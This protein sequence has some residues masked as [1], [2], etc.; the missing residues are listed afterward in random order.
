M[1]RIAVFPNRAKPGCAEVLAKLCRWLRRR[2]CDVRVAESESRFTASGERLPAFTHREL[3]EFDLLLVLGG[4][5]T[6]L[7]AARMIYPLPLPILGVNF[8]SLGFLAETTVESVYPVLEQVLSGKAWR[9]PRMMLQVSTADARGREA[10]RTHG[11]NDLVLREAGG[12]AVQIEAMISGSLLGEFRADGI[13]VAT[14]TGSTAYSLSAGGPIVEPTLNTLIATPI[15]PHTLS[16]RPLVFPAGQTAEFRVR[17]IET[18]VTLMVDGQVTLQ[19]RPGDTV[20]VRRATRPIHFLQVKERTFYEV[21][22]AKL[23]WGVSV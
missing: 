5:G 7:S 14:P 17:P 19:F 23:R 11:L 18:E 22:R 6:I 2:K 12:R 15:C 8:G 9:Q 3:R 21:L 10:E 1:K 20:R 16:I 4:D 13:I